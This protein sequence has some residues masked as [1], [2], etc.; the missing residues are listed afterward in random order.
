[1]KTQ[2]LKQRKRLTKA[3]VRARISG[4]KSRPRLSVRISNANIVAQ[5]I[6]D[7]AAKT[8]ASASTVGQKALVGKTMTEKADW[9]GQQIAKNAKD[10]KITTIVF[11][12]GYR[13]YHGRIKHLAE[14]ARA[15]GLEF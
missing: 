1:M 6:D 14:A 8:L 7:S 2:T 11:D 12:R 15:G 5:L 9:I 13:T 3:R 10:A 4:S